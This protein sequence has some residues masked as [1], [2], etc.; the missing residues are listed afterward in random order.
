MVVGV[1]VDVGTSVVVGVFV[2][3]GSGEAV[4]VA[5]GVGDGDGFWVGGTNTTSG[6]GTA[7]TGCITPLKYV[8]AMS[9]RQESRLLTAGIW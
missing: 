1:G 6:V 9:M 4:S 8:L 7:S 3:G 2:P 5:L